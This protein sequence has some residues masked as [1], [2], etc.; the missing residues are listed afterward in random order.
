VVT[1]RKA[2]ATISQIPGV[3]CPESLRQR[4]ESAT[5]IRQTGIDIAREMIAELKQCPGVS[6]V[7]LMLFGSDHSVLPEIINPKHQAQS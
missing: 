1:S 6:G 7:H 3:Y 2:F 4:I 5:D